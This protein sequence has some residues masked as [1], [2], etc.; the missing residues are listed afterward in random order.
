M[1]HISYNKELQRKLIHLSSIWMPIAIW[2]LTYMQSL[3]LFSTLFIFMAISEL[4]RI[5]VKFFYH[6]YDYFFGG[7]MRLHELRYTRSSFVGTFYFVLAVLLAVL[8]FSKP[9]T[10]AAVSVMVTAD[11]AAALIGKRFGK[12][13]I[14]D[15]SLEGCLAFLVTGVITII[16]IYHY[17]KLSELF[18]ISGIIGVAVTAVIELI[19]SRIKID[20]NLSIVMS[21]GG[22]MALCELLIL[23]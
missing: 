14:L 5:N 1:T 17:L 15:K 19:S 12:I 11:S 9:I 4:L 6:I 20:D 7:M 13:K 18:L 23:K 2:N 10:V 8:M 3:F 22:I 21:M 16:F